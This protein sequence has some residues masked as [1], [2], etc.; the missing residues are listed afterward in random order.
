MTLKSLKRDYIKLLY[1]HTNEEAPTPNKLARGP[2]TVK[3]VPKS[4][5]EEYPLV[6]DKLTDQFSHRRGGTT[7]SLCIDSRNLR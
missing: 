4:S 1:L 2:E 3:I 5:A 6:P 7:E